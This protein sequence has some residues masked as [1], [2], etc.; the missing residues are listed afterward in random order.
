MAVVVAVLVGVS[1]AVGVSD[2][3]GVP[4]GSGVAVAV[5]VAVLG[6]VGVGVK[7]GLGIFSLTT[8]MGVVV[9]VAGGTEVLRTVWASLTGVGVA[10]NQPCGLSSSPTLA[11]RPVSCSISE[12]SAGRTRP[13][14][15]EGQGL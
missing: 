14:V 2:G 11:E 7:V 4:L 1:V 3:V 6:G 10:Q 8:T 13:N 5:K 9:G 12:S 15:S